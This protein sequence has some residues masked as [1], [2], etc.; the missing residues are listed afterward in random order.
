MARSQSRDALR[1]KKNGTPIKEGVLKNMNN[2]S[3]TL[4]SD[5]AS[6]KLVISRSNTRQ[7]A[8]SHNLVRVRDN[9]EL[10]NPKVRISAI[11]ERHKIND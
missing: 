2:A 8:S 6:R 10:S 11:K 5:S 3:N 1:N 7:P 9:R 4:D